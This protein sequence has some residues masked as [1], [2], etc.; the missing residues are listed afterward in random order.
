MDSSTDANHIAVS[1][2][3]QI[4]FLDCLIQTRDELLLTSHIDWSS[5]DCENAPNDLR[6]CHQVSNFFRNWLLSF[7]FP[8]SSF[9]FSFL[10][11]HIHLKSLRLYY[12]FGDMKLN[13]TLPAKKDL[14][15]KKK[16][17]RRKERRKNVNI[18]L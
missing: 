9:L 18:N 13:S 3:F 8:L 6:N 4:S 12:R 5:N 10:F 16:K 2:G 17:E 1:K 7:L 15:E 14:G 11:I